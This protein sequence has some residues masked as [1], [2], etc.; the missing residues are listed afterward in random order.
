M[1]ERLGAAGGLPP[2]FIAAGTSSFTEFL[3]IAAPDL[4]P[5]RRPLHAA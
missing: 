5:G 3:S 1:A 2:A 4:L